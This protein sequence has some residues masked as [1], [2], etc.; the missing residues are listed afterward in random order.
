MRLKKTIE[1]IAYI[2]MIVNR[3]ASFLAAIIYKCR[4]GVKNLGEFSFIQ[5]KTVIFMLRFIS[6]AHL[7]KRK[8]KLSSETLKQFWKI[9]KLLTLCDV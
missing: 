4:F 8:K 9:I 7:L 5:L 3:T 2:S 6:F 1:L